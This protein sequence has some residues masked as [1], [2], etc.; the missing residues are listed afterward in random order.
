[1]LDGSSFLTFLAVCIGLILAPGPGQALTIARTLSGGFR[2]GILTATGLNLG[3]LVH[4]LAAGLGLSA[5][6][7]TSALAFSIVKYVGAAYL[8][9]LGISSL[10]DR[11]R[12]EPKSEATAVPTGSPLR[13]ATLAGLL[14]PKVAVFF[15]AFLPQ[16][17]DPTLGRVPLQFFLLGLTMAL[18]DTVY[19]ILLAWLTSRARHRLAARPALRRLQR[20]VTGSVLILLGLRLA[21]QER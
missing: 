14:N 3:T 18:L 17:V 4:A 21:A 8:L 9:F 16:F 10:R 5:V 15:L 1:M 12:D 2:A 11:A 7:A 20:T 6:L 19:E 13:Q